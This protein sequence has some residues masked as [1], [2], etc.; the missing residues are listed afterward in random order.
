MSAKKI[1][2]IT[3]SLILLSTLGQFAM[4]TGQLPQPPFDYLQPEKAWIK[5]NGFPR[6]TW[7]QYNDTGRNKLNLTYR[8]SAV[9]IAYV[10]RSSDPSD[11]VNATFIVYKNESGSNGFNSTGH[12]FTGS[13][14]AWTV[15]I[16][17]SSESTLG[18]YTYHLFI[19]TYDPEGSPGLYQVRI[20]L[21]GTITGGSNWTE[22]DGNPNVPWMFFEVPTGSLWP[23]SVSDQIGRFT[24]FFFDTPIPSTFFNA[25]LVVRPPGNSTGASTAQVRWNHTNGTT[26]ATYNPQVYYAGDGKWATQSIIPADNA[27]FPANY[28]HPYKVDIRMGSYEHSATF[29]VYPIYAALL[30]ETWLTQKPPATLDNGTARFA[31]IGSDLDGSVIAYQ[32]K[33][34]SGGWVET[35]ETNRTYHGLANGTHRFEVRAV[36]DDGLVDSSPA[37]RDF[38]VLLN[39]P[40]ETWIIIAPNATTNLRDVFFEWQGSDVEGFVASY[41]YRLD[42][43]PWVNTLLTNKTYLNLSSGNHTFQVRSRDDKDLEDHTPAVAT[44][45]ILPS[46][47][48]RELERLNALI[49][50][51]N[52]RIE[53]LEDI[54]ANL[55]S[56]LEDAEGANSILSIL[57]EDLEEEKAQLALLVEQ[58]ENEKS[59]LQALVDSLSS[60][61]AELKEDLETC[62]NL[63]LDLQAQLELLTSEVYRLNQT[64]INLIW[65]KSHLESGREYLL[66]LITQLRERIEELESQ[67]P[68]ISS[69]SWT[70]IF[71]LTILTGLAG[72]HH[73][74]GS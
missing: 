37:Y 47:C 51:L 30:P 72:K 56:L 57:V 13:V 38:T 52:G 58:L 18:E 26:I 42:S 5:E 62:G 22:P 61:N 21:T 29:Y 73:R 50:A 46:W 36:D 14:P 35:V 27:T 74:K 19:A 12:L 17:L 41:D 11:E 4:V 53:E 69:M 60:E 23:V 45:R 64:V 3:T 25:T 65:E 20:N 10:I 40:P 49:D 7:D 63:T 28:T 32:Y 43:E 2:I 66:A 31:W 15:M 55:T 8:H 44:F 24:P 16:S 67:I 9:N 39:S 48:E 70:G 68:E 1:V 33:M 34:D 6:D 54:I 59:Q 71:A